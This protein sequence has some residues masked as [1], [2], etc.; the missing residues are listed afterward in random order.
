ME[1]SKYK[2]FATCLPT[3]AKP[4]EEKKKKKIVEEY[5]SKTALDQAISV[6]QEYFNTPECS[7]RPALKENMEEYILANQWFPAE[8]LM[9]DQGWARRPIS[10]GLYGK[11]YMNE[12]YKE[13]CI[14]QFN[15]GVANKGDKQSPSQTLELMEENFPGL[16]CYPGVHE[17]V[18]MYSGLV[19]QYKDHGKVQSRP[20]P[21]PLVPPEIKAELQSLLNDHPNLTAKP[22]F[23][24]WKAQF[25]MNREY[26]EEKVQKQAQYL[27]QKLLSDTK[28]RLKR[29]MLG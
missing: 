10:G 17:I 21:D 22:L 26:D 19:K 5:E 1:V 4:K 12:E 16:Y 14:T 23:A 9:W 15:R 8:P 24:L 11:N 29:N 7:I 27:R 18:R 20:K 6:A 13:I 3:K 25:A 28:R 2:P